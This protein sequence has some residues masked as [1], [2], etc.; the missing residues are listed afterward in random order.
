MHPF[1]SAAALLL[2]A[3]APMAAHAQQDSELQAIR[4]Q[5]DELRQHYERDIRALER[6]LK[7]AEAA[8]AP[9]PQAGAAPTAAEP[10]AV[11]DDAQTASA[12]PAAAAA[13]PATAPVS[14]PASGPSAFNPGIS[15]ILQGSYRHFR[16][17]PAERGVTGYVPAGEFDI[18]E[19]GFSLDESEIT[20]SASVD[21]LFFGQATFALEDGGI[22]VEE[23][24]VRTPALGHGL[25]VKLGRFFSGIGYENALHP[26]ARDF[27]DPSLPQTVL[28][29]GNLAMD[30]LQV[31]W[32]APLPLLVEVGA[33][34]GMPVEFPLED[35]DSNRNGATGAALFA[36]VGGDIGLSHSYRV[37]AWALRA[38]NRF[39]DAP[40]LD[41]A[42]RF[43]SGSSALSGGHTRMWGLNLVYKW[44]PDGNPQY[45][46]VAFVAE[47]M[48]RRLDGELA[49][50]L[51]GAPDTG[52]FDARQSGW[53][54]QGVYQFRPHWRM[55][56]RYDRLDEGDYDLA[57]N[58]AG[59]VAPAGFDPRRWS[60]MLDWNPS[61]YS[62]IRL[63]YTQD[64]SQEGLRD[65]QVFLQYLFSLGAH[66]AHQF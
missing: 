40:V 50:D 2:A 3:G 12:S 44:A 25:T 8:A 65:D 63:Q 38:A 31:N 13:A 36:R 15:L 48:Q 5:I 30:A 29:G 56:L 58:L 6:R 1:R 20:V 33:E 45:R 17:D 39:K 32:I 26:H 37:G 47:W 53:S 27:L 66:G 24:F 57:P 35:S 16:T 42:E 28:L 10:P 9:A 23:A 61:E 7:A 52:A 46:N 51:G 41:F 64:R 18:G 54:L 4:R 21:H 43:D 19:R 14:A 55:G 59:T 34:I 11:A 22:E 60:A 49:T 62:R